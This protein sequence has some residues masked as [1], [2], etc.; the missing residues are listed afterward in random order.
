[1]SFTTSNWSDAGPPVEPPPVPA[2]AAAAVNLDT[3]ELAPGFWRD[4][5]IDT[6][7][8][9]QTT[10]RI[11]IDRVSA[12]LGSNSATKKSI[13]SRS[14]TKLAQQAGTP[15]QPF[16]DF[17]VKGATRT[18]VENAINLVHE[19]VV[20]PPSSSSSSSRTDRGPDDRDASSSSKRRHEERDGD[21]ERRSRRDSES[22]RGGRATSPRSTT[23][24]SNRYDRDGIRSPT[25]GSS[26]GVGGGGLSSSASYQSPVSSSRDGRGGRRDSS[27]GSS[28]S[29]RDL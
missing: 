2:V 27:R 13:E 3:R 29:N 4:N 25:R 10:L 18:Q 24:S 9:A 19:I 7:T 1:M 21:R 16:R 6:A 17:V 12:V 28:S 11:P 22:D 14:G 20:A 8:E 23:N 26:S 5:S 15:D